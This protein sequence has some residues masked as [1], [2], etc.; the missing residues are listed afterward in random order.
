MLSELH[1]DNIAVIEHADIGFHS[2]LNVLTGETG[3]GKSIVIDSL[4]AVLGN[5]V[6]RDL[7]RRGAN[8]AL[9]TAV[10][11]PEA[12]LAWLE[13]NDIPEEEEL[14]VQRKISP[15]GKSSC[16]INGLPVTAAQLKELG[17]FLMD[18]HGQNDGMKLL[19]EK[20]HL[21]YLDRFG[22][23]DESAAAYREEYGKLLQIE[24]E[25]RSLSMNEDEKLRLT[26]ALQ[27]QID[28]LEKAELTA[29]EYDALTARRDLLHNSEKLRE[30]LDEALGCLRDGEE[31]A[32]AFTENAEY[33][34]SRASRFAQELEGAAQSLKDASFALSDAAEVLS[35]YRDSL[36]FSPREYDELES[37]I[38]RLD[39]LSRKYNRDEA[40]LIELLEESRKKLDDIEYSSDRI[41]KLKRSAAGQEKLCLEKAKE[42][43]LVRRKAAQELEKRIVRELKELNMPS[44]RFAVEFSP[45]ENRQGFDADGCDVIR[46]IMSANA[47]EEMGRISRIASGGELSRIMLALKNVFAEH[48]IVGT[49]IFDEIDT[50]V[51]GISAQRVAEKLYSVSSN[52][53]VM[54][55]THLPQIAAMADSEYL[56]YKSEEKGRTF[57]RVEELDLEGRKHEIARLYGG[58]NVTATT[59]AA[60][61]EQLRAA[62]AFKNKTETK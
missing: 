27:F 19:D 6:S 62:E 37:R 18:I 3:A 35:D 60:A 61:E 20:E 28:E 11:R 4:N 32:I 17:G 13:E 8:G 55:V 23:T 31:N 53:Q 33:Y 10:F 29:G 59:L 7:V 2:G 26:D 21:S 48:D 15:E 56:V 34:A 38:S 40:A 42:L 51:S 46:F 30:A 43:S 50:G 57:T 5:R 36:D 12:T 58:D 45:V 47:G 25:I 39:R 52:R 14:I 24:K 49:M 22:E 1:I 44:V 41:E 54:C 9:V 16:R